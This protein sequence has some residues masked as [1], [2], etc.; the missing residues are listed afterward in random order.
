MYDS[1]QVR[2]DLASGPLSAQGHGGSQVNAS[3]PHWCRGLQLVH[4][5]A[6]ICIELCSSFML[7]LGGWV[8]TPWYSSLLWP[9]SPPLLHRVS[10]HMSSGWLGS[11]PLAQST[12][13]LSILYSGTS[14][15]CC[16]WPA[17]PLP[18]PAGAAGAIIPTHAAALP[19][20]HPTP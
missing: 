17:P 7:Y 3:C 9:S 4:A 8:A 13:V 10:Q 5:V 20:A 12:A 1:T 16:S 18:L 2:H 14:R 6:T 11:G 19:A 15:C